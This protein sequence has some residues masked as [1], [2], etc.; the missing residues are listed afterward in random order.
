MTVIGIA[1]APAPEEVVTV[2]LPRLG[3]G[4]GGFEVFAAVLLAVTKLH[5]VVTAAGARYTGL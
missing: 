3:S 4:S 2:V 1:A 5:A